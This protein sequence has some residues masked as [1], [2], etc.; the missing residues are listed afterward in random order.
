MAASSS[1][2]AEVVGAVQLDRIQQ[3]ISGDRQ[4]RPPAGQLVLV[5]VVDCGQTGPVQLAQGGGDGGRTDWAAASGGE[6][7][8]ELVDAPSA[9]QDARG[10]EGHGRETPRP[11]LSGQSHTQ[12]PPASTSPSRSS[13]GAELGSV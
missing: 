13:E 3:G 6:S 7:G 1:Q 4:R 11:L 8:G 9:A 10:A 12:P 5:E 2:V